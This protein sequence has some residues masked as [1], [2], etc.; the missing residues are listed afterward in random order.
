[1]RYPL[2]A[3]GVVALAGAIFPQE[4]WRKVFKR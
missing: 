2:I 4:H 1:V 3:L